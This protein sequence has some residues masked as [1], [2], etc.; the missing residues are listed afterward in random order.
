MDKWSRLSAKAVVF[1]LVLGVSTFGIGVLG[2]VARAEKI[3]P[4]STVVVYDQTLSVASGSIVLTPLINV[5]TFKQIR[6]VVGA[7]AGNSCVVFIVDVDDAGNPL[8]ALDY[9]PESF[10]VGDICTLNRAY[11]TPGMAI[12]VQMNNY[13]QTT[14]DFRVTVYGQP[15]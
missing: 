11:D 1:G 4:P 7:T 2:N 14:N 5:S 13:F 12:K 3:A 15:Y 6:V 10:N 9:A 8:R